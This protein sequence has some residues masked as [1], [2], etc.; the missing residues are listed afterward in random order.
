[1]SKILEAKRDSE[2]NLIYNILKQFTLNRKDLLNLQNYEKE[3]IYRAFY[4]FTKEYLELLLIKAKKLYPNK[5][6]DIIPEEAY[7]K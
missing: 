2:E 4:K 7:K 1:M 3:L 6:T 5:L